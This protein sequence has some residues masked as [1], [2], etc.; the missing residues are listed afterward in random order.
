MFYYTPGTNNNSFT[1]TPSAA[2]A[3][4]DIVHNIA[5]A[6][7]SI[8]TTYILN[9]NPMV[10]DAAESYCNDM[11]GHLASWGSSVSSLYRHQALLLVTDTARHCFMHLDAA[12]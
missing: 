10:F 9:T 5:G 6:L 3:S 4:G 11:G 12:S 7:T 8:N 2:S 1:I